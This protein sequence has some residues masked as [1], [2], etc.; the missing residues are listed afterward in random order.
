MNRKTKEVFQTHKYVSFLEDLDCFFVIFGEQFVCEMSTR[1]F[2]SERNGS[3]TNT[4]DA[5][6]IFWLFPYSYANHNGGQCV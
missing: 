1:D 3:P 4:Q 6:D 5:E 2:T